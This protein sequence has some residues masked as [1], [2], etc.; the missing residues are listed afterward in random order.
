MSEVRRP[1]A[2]VETVPPELAE[3]KL[4]KHTTGNRNV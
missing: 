3:G 4:K 1:Q 2:W